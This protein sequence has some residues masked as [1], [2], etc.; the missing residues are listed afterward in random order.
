MSSRSMRIVAL[1]AHALLIVRL[2]A[3]VGATIGLLLVLPLLA[4][5]RGLWRGDR[6][7]YAWNA[8]LIVFYCAGFLAEAYMRPT[9]ARPFPAAAIVAAI[10]F[11]SAV[12]FVRL[13]AREARAAAA[14]PPPAA[15]TGA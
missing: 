5:L 7:T 10:E 1:V 15:R 12:L 6:Y 8:M 3:M 11:V 13:R 9:I 14:D 4:P 2:S